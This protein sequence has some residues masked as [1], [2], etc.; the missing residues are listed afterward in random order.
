MFGEVAQPGSNGIQAAPPDLVTLDLRH[1][2][3]DRLQ[4]I[5]ALRRWAEGCATMVLSGAGNRARELPVPA[6]ELG[7]FD[8]LEKPGG[9]GAAENGAALREQ[10]APR[11]AALVHQKEVRARLRGDS[12]VAIASPPAKGVHAAALVPEPL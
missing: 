7:A 12:A 9:A 6:L 5:K 2:G 10:L 1:A 3:I 8:F 11:V 4:V